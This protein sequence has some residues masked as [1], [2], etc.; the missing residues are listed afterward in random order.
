ML[1]DEAPHRLTATVDPA[2]VEGLDAGVIEEARRRQRRHRVMAALALVATV[3]AGALAFDFAGEADRSGPSPSVR[4]SPL[5]RGLAGPP[6]RGRTG[7]QLVV[8]GIAGRGPV[9][10]VDV[11]SGKVR[12]LRGLGVSGSL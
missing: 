1:L 10:I 12:A 7:L 3:A 6:L 4:L 5:L 2:P 8:A 11:D 9:D